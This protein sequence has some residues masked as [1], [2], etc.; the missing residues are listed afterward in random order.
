MSIAMWNLVFFS[1]LIPGFKVKRYD[2][3]LKELTLTNTSSI[4]QK[5][6]PEDILENEVEMDLGQRV[7]DE[8]RW[9]PLVL[10][11][12]YV[13]KYENVDNNQQL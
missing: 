7:A 1:R 13:L 12:S 10:R 2:N 3:R 6:K 8:H 5:P 9:V 11:C 4:T